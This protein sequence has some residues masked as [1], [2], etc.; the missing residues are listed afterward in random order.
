MKQTP[1]GAFLQGY[2]DHLIDMYKFW[3]TIPANSIM[4]SAMEFVNGYILE[5]MPVLREMQSSHTAQAW[6]YH[7]RAKTGGAT[8]YAY[9]IFPKEINPNMSVYIQ[10][11]EDISLYIN[12]VNDILSYVFLSFLINPF[13]NDNSSGFT[14]KFLRERRI[15][16]FI[17]GHTS[18]RNPFRTLCKTSTMTH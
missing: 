15:T 5:G 14:R 1:D 16:T 8:A 6:P 4:I 10:V 9:M 17:L 3:D 11:V 7:V 18:L 12:L 2:R 13:S